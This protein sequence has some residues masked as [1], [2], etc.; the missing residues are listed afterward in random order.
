MNKKDQKS[1]TGES[2]PEILEIE[3]QEIEEKE[4]PNH[5]IIDYKIVDNKNNS[6]FDTDKI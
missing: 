5:R 1:R 3:E 4:P 2:I 6:N